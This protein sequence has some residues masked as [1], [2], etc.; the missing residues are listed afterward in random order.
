MM[1]LHR[2]VEKIGYKNDA[3]CGSFTSPYSRHAIHS[4][5]VLMISF[6]Y[7]TQHT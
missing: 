1:L 3:P 7:N 5:L 2:I 4:L 6:N